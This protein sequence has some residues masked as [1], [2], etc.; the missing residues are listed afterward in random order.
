MIA[1]FL[2]R[3]FLDYLTKI[4]LDLN[5]PEFEAL[6]G[7][8]LSNSTSV[9]G[10]CSGGQI[11]AL[12]FSHSGNRYLPDDNIQKIKVL[13]ISDQVDAAKKIVLLRLLG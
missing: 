4:G 1:Y 13:K 11:S 5:R 8:M 9:R 2:C 12:G 7:F 6:K 10:A 3:H